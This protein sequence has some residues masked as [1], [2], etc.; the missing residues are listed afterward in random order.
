M[1][2][3]AENIPQETPTREYSEALLQ[4]AIERLKAR[5]DSTRR[6]ACMALPAPVFHDL[7][8]RLLQGGATVRG[9]AEWLAGQVVDAPTR[10]SVERFSDAL[11]EEYRLVQLADRRRAAETYIAQA[12]AG[13]PDAQQMALNTRLTE[14]L[15]D[16]LLRADD[17]GSIET[18]RFMALMMGARTVAQTA[19]DKQKM[20]AR[21]SALQTLV[22]KMEAE[23]QLKDQRIQAEEAK[24]A[25]AIAEGQKVATSGGGAAA[26]VDTIKR[27]LGITGGAA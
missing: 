26:V 1:S 15:T 5:G 3:D 6:M 13:D 19:F 20:D 18:K 25:A 2:E 14:L 12:T 7:C 21:L 10:S 8:A 23:I 16:E 22:K 17:A 4:A 9:T 27:A 24:R 11:Y